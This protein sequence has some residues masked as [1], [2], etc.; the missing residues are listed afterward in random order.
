MQAETDCELLCVLQPDL[1]RLLQVFH[2]DS[3]LINSAAIARDMQI[4]RKICSEPHQ[5]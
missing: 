4:M 3:S 2:D 5:V 1:L